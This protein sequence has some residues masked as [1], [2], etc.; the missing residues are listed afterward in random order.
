MIDYYYSPTN[1]LQCWTCAIIAHYLK[2]NNNYI[3]YLIYSTRLTDVISFDSA[4]HAEGLNQPAA[5]LHQA[6][7]VGT[8]TELNGRKGTKTCTIG[9]IR[10][11][12]STIVEKI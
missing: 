4:E 12:P 7:Q 2:K 1:I 10:K 8:G 3:F 11:Y 6:V 9:V 5:V